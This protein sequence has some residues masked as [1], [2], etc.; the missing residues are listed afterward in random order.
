[1]ETPCVPSRSG[2]FIPPYATANRSTSKPSSTSPSG[3]LN[4]SSD[5]WPCA[6]SCRRQ[7]QEIWLS[8]SDRRLSVSSALPYM[9]NPRR[10]P[11]KARNRRSEKEETGKRIE[12]RE[13]VAPIYDVNR[14]ELYR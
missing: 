10:K 7:E 5:S 14:F 11:D 9:H 2:S 13:T 4:V 3:S 12:P 8:R 6:C 1:M